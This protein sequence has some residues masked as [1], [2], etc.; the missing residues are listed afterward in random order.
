MA[1]FTCRPLVNP[2]LQFRTLT[3]ERGEYHE[4]LRGFLTEEIL[5][6]S[7]PYHPISYHCGPPTHI[8]EIL[9]KSD[10][11][12]LPLPITENLDLALR[13][14]RQPEADI[15]IW[16]DAICINQNNDEEKA[17]QVRLMNGIYLEANRVLICLGEQGALWEGELDMLQRIYSAACATSSNDTRPPMQWISAHQL[18]DADQPDR[19]EALKLFFRRPWFRRKWTVQECTLAKDPVFFCGTW[20]RPWQWLKIV[21][22]T[23]CKYGLGAMDWTTYS[24]PEAAYQLQQGLA[25]FHFIMTLRTFRQQDKAPEFMVNAYKLQSSR[26]SDRRDHLFSLL[27]ISFGANVTELEPKYGTENVLKTCLRYAHYF[28]RTK[29]NLEVLCRAGLQGHRLLAP[30]WVCSVSASDRHTDFQF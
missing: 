9:L 5:G 16:A 12:Y 30:S 4:P 18:P 25:Q 7:Q 14:F 22:E 3:L 19:W 20:S 15:V 11:Q 2:N 8:S 17:R 26:A 13:R 10:A 1:Q 23:I 6:K 27:G 24:D 29:N 28:L 21:E